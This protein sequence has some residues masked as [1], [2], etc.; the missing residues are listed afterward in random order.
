M[1]MR[2]P[3]RRSTLDEILNDDF[4]T[5]Q[6]FPKTLPMSLLACPPNSAFLKQYAD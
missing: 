4:F 1:L 3:S 2:E 6:P 5:S